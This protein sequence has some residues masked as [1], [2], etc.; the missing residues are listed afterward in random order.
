M[1]ILLKMIV[2]ASISITNSIAD[3]TITTNNLLDQDFNNWTGN[4][5]ILNDSIHND[6]VLAGIENG[7]AEYIIN[8]ADTG[9]SSDIIN[10]G[11]SSTLGA[12]IWFWSQSDQTVKM[13]QTYDDGNGNI[14]NQHRTIT[15]TCGN[16][17]YTNHNY[18]TFTD[19]LIVGEN[20][21]TNGSVT[22]RFDFNSSYNNPQN[23]L[24]HNGADVEHP[25]LNIT[26]T[27]PEIV[28]PPIEEIIIDPVIEFVELPVFV[29][30]IEI[31]EEE[32]EDVYIAE[33]PIST[34]QI[35]ESEPTTIVAENE[36][37]EEPQEEIIEIEEEQIAE[38]MEADIIEPE[39][40]VEE[41]EVEVVEN[42]K[43]IIDPINV[44]TNINTQNMLVSEPS[45][46]EYKEVQMSDVIKLPETDIKFF[47]QINLEGYNKT[48]YDSKKQ[49]LAMLLSDPIYRYQVK[50][51]NAKSATDRAFKKL[52]ESI[53][54]RNNI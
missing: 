12:D 33:T 53:G 45:L 8:Q 20:T 14:V 39:E 29:E 5:P 51:Q 16:E 44:V 3:E 24:W 37:V 48:I 18:N 21:A 54:A 41:I 28:L 38:T 19:T 4:I 11:F 30:P 34:G 1:K 15:G 25:T 22:A 27:L 35:D 49:K 13:T 32:I 7:Y 52:Q 9:L 40:I 42:N 43:P 47:E 26:Y 6:E 23:P 10:R 36:P 50:L 46:Q 31:I 17:C 2:V